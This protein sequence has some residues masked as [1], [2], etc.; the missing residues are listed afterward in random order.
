VRSVRVVSTPFQSTCLREARRPSPG[1]RR[2]TSDFNPRAYVRHDTPAPARSQDDRDFNP[3]AYVRHDFRALNCSIRLVFQSTCLREARQTMDLCEGQDV[4]FNPRAYV[5]HDRS[6]SATRRRMPFQSTCLREARRSC[7]DDR[8]RAGYFNP[9]AYV[10]HDVRGRV[11]PNSFAY[12][13]PRAYVRHDFIC[14]AYYGEVTFQSTCLRE[15][16]LALDDYEG[17]LTGFQ[18][19]CLREARLCV[20]SVPAPRPH[21]NP[22][23]YVR[24]DRT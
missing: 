20:S 18:S 21:F 22:R 13:N 23:A 5:R 9:R 4:Y 16:R 3:R 2:L 14:G 24:H 6:R 12:F 15:A 11:I 8:R 19:T 10:R 1:R 17:D 7:C